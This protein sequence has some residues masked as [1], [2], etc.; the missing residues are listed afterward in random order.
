LPAFKKFT[1]YPGFSFFRTFSILSI[2]IQNISI[3]NLFSKTFRGLENQGK[4][5]QLSGRRINHEEFN[6]KLI[7]KSF[8]GL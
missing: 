2:N 8:P 3:Q 1:N 7:T 4:N 5:P 6:P